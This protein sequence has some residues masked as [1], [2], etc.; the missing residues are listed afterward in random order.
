MSWRI[1]LPHTQCPYRFGPL[2]SR[3]GRRAICEVK[4][5]TCNQKNCPYLIKRKKQYN[6]T[7][8]IRKKAEI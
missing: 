1:N 7:Y 4:D 6:G 5:G 8:K 3:A 2:G